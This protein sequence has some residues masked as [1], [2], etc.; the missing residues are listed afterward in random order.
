MGAQFCCCWRCVGLGSHAMLD[1]MLRY[2][3]KRV[4]YRWRVMVLERDGVKRKK[5]QSVGGL[6]E[7]WLGVQ[8]VV[9]RTVC[10]IQ[11]W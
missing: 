6:W 1:V 3:T 2:V 4:V 8:L 10:E 9:C 7:F 5:R 11:V